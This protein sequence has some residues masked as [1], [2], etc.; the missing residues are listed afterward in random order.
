MRIF[1]IKRVNFFRWILLLGLIIPL[2]G[3]FEWF[4]AYQT[5]LQLEDFDDHFAT[6]SGNEFNLLF[7]HPT[8]YDE[9]LIALSKLYPSQI[10]PLDHGQCWRYWFKKIDQ[11]NNIIHPEINFYF[12]LRFNKDNHLIQWTFSPLFLQIAPAQFLELSLRSL[13][14]AKIDQDKR[15]LKANPQYIQKIDVPLPAKNAVLKQLGEPIE[16]VDEPEQQI[17]SYRFKL[18][19]QQIEAGYEANALTLIQL[20]FDK[21]NHTLTRMSGRFAGL[22]LSINYQKYI[23]H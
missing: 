1:N 17:Y 6:V 4:R 7:K 11:N 16:I 8:L 19:S 12:D 22:K 13:S 23:A 15:Q 18:D 21:K 10:T 3:C 20:T 2:T 9:D 14:G 5:Y